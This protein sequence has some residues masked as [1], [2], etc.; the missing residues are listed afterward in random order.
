MTRHRR[1]RI[2]RDPT[3]R[4]IVVTCTCG[5]SYTVP[6]ATTTTEQDLLER[7]QHAHATASPTMF[8][9]AGCHYGDFADF[10]H[11]VDLNNIPDEQLGEAFADYLRLEHNWAG[12]T[13]R[14]NLHDTD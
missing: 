5:Q 6:T 13:R 12:W 10:D 1:Q 11:Y 2:T 9:R 4:R 3:R 14:I 8:C 7:A